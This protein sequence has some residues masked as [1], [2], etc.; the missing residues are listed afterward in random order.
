MNEPMHDWIESRLR[1]TRLR[2]TLARRQVLQAFSERSEYLRTDDIYRQLIER[3]A[4]VSIGAEGDMDDSNGFMSRKAHYE[5]RRPVAIQSALPLAPT[6]RAAE[7]PHG[8][9]R[10]CAPRNDEVGGV[11]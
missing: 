6:F 11:A 8:L 2:P 10:R 9:P 1:A 4:P 5:G 7:P 3:G